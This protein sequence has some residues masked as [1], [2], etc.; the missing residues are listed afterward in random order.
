[1][2]LPLAALAAAAQCVKPALRRLGAC[3]DSTFLN[4]LADVLAALP[5]GLVTL[6]LQAPH[7]G[8][9]RLDGRAAL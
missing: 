3:M 1:M 7:L 9:R 6:R 8:H 4:L 2:S 5:L